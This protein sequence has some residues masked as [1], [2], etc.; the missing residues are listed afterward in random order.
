MLLIAALVGLLVAVVVFMLWALSVTPP[1][2]RENSSGKD[3][4]TRTRECEC[5]D[6]M[7][8]GLRGPSLTSL[9]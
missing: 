4:A 1:T 9:D 2:Q 3:V 6:C 5:E 7:E 8:P